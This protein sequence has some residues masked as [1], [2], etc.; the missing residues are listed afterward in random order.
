MRRSKDLM[1]SRRR[2][3]PL[4]AL[5][6]CALAFAGCATSAVYSYLDRGADLSLYTRYSWG[7]FDRGGTGDPRLDNNEIFQE[8]VQAAVDNQLATKGFEKTV[9]ESPELLVHYHASIEQRIDLSDTEPSE[10]CPDC[11]PFIYDAGTLVIDLV[12]ARTNKVIW[13]GWSEGN[14]DGVVDN[15]RWLEERIDDDVTRIFE[16]FPR[17]IR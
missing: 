12:D 16:Q 4:T 9:S 6:V 8:H 15:Q 5:G 1:D 3:W 2:L 7:P 10:S 14:V 13:R 17:G 11:R